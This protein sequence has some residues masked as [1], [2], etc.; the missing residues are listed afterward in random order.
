MSTEDESDIAGGQVTRAPDE[1][2][3]CYHSCDEYAVVVVPEDVS[4]YEDESPLDMRLGNYSCKFVTNIP[5]SSNDNDPSNPR[6]YFD[7]GLRHFFAYHHEEAYKCFLACLTLAPNCAFAHGMVALCHCPNYNFKGSAYYESTNHLEEEQTVL[8]EAGENGEDISIMR[9]LYPSQQVASNHALLAIEKI[10]ELKKRQQQHP[11]KRRGSAR[12]GEVDQNSQVISDVETQILSAIRTLTCHPGVHPQLAEE[13][14][15]RPYADAL[16]KIHQRFPEDA[17]VSCFFAEA[18]MVL[19]AWNLYEYPTGRPLSQDVEEIQT[20]LEDA[21]LLHPKHAGICHLYVHLCEM[22]THPEKALT[23][24]EALRSDFPDAG[25]LIHMPTHIDVLVGDYEL[26]V[27]YNLSAILADEKIMRTSPDTAG[28]ESFYF[29][30]IVHNFHMLVYGAILGGMESI[31]MQKAL[32]L[33]EYLHEDL[34]VENHDLTAYLESYAALD[35]HTMVR[36]GWWETILQIPFPRYPLL[37]LFR[38]ASLHYARGL[39]LANTGE[40]EMA[41]TEANLLDDLRFN[42]SAELRILHNNKVSELLAVDASMLRG[43]IAYFSGKYDEAF[44]LLRQAVALQDGLN[45]DEP[46]GKMMPIRHPLGGLLYEQGHYEEAEKVFRI[47]LKFHPKNPWGLVGLIGCLNARLNAGQDSCCSKKKKVGSE[48]QGKI[49]G[50]EREDILLEVQQLSQLLVEQR[51][52][53]WADYD[54]SAPCVCCTKKF[55]E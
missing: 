18:L 2:E 1:S 34:F 33:N 3:K 4:P 53:K 15:G 46:W 40:I 35:I 20:V 42:P 27:E 28:S 43:E 17:E 23:A 13:T 12:E 38:S 14:V 21:L 32:E 36:F 8:A 11:R 29:G 54:I 52:S 49:V 39:A 50:K 45:Y 51:K 16:R 25:H 26:C 44:P 55:N 9:R 5:L 30:Y 48:A 19:N 24:C 31:A 6:T 7:L 10:E 47:D 41:I 37:M 22:S